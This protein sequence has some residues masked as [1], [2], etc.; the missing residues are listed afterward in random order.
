MPIRS[1]STS[2]E[3]VHR[4]QEIFRVDV[5]GGHPAGLSPAFTGKGRIESKGY[6]PTLRHVLGVEAAALLLHGAK[7]T[8][9]RDGGQ[10]AGT[11]P[12]HVHIGRQFNAVAVMESDLAVIDKF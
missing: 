12:G 3:K 1:G 2:G 5:R 4:G 6:E 11:L 10:L 9:D 7:G 8:A